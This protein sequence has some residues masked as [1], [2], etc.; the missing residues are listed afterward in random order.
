MNFY[1]WIPATIVVLI[2]VL[3]HPRR[4]A[5]IPFV[6]VDAVLLA[7]TYSQPPTLMWTWFWHSTVVGLGAGIF[8][9]WRY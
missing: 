9:A 5:L 3:A 2:L 4:R 8:A 7:M 1:F 6:L